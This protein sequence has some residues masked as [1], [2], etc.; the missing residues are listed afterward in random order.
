MLNI[1]YWFNHAFNMCSSTMLYIGWL[2]IGNPLSHC[3][4]SLLADDYVLKEGGANHGLDT[5]IHAYQT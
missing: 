2:D 3:S 5:N 1:A 4:L